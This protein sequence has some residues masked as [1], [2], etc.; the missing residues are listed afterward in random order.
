MALLR[1][2]QSKERFSADDV[3]NRKLLRLD[4]AASELICIFAHL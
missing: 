1:F 2:G 4:V 3:L